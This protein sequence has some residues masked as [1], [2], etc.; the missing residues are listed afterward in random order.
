MKRLNL[1]PGAV[2]AWGCLGLCI[3]VAVAATAMALADPHGFKTIVATDSKVAPP[4]TYSFDI[5]I[6][7]PHAKAPAR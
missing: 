6:P 4:T 3:A 5:T 1:Y 7:L 2:A